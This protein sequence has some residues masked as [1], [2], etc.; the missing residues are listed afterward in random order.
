MCRAPA[1][2]M[3]VTMS[4]LSDLF[5]QAQCEV[6][7]HAPER[8]AISEESCIRRTVTSRTIRLFDPDQ[9]R[10][11]FGGG[12]VEHRLL[13]PGSFNAHLLRIDTAAF[14]LEIIRHSLPVAITGEWPAGRIVLAF[15]LNLPEGAVALG[16]S[17]YTGALA[18][19]DG[20][21]GIDARLPAGTEWAI[22]ILDRERFE[23]EARKRGG[24]TALGRSSA[25]CPLRV[26]DPETRRLGDLLHAVADSPALTSHLL[27]IPGAASVF[28]QQILGAYI[29]AFA[30]AQMPLQNC[31]GSLH[32]RY[33][34]VRKAERYVFA[35][36]D[37]SV[38]MGRLSREV[39][40]SPRSLEYAF[41]AVYGMGAMQYLRTVRLNEV[42]KA[43]LRP[44]DSALTTVTATAMDWGF[45][46]LGEFSA[47]YRRL[48]GEVPSETLRCRCQ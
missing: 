2:G 1:P 32:R 34:L 5:S 40:A 37:E 6:I 8:F 12:Q 46:H 3:G 13:E 16:Q 19:F 23:T 42:R 48:F 39:G 44:A 9:L 22:L 29:M 31:R 4:F 28:E 15:G 24:E 33:G 43:L 14:A 20:T 47:A 30:T 11:A 7:P 35:H 17:H 18:L 45:W 36:L 27:Q 10:E 26:D 38:R 41:R 21:T 25:G